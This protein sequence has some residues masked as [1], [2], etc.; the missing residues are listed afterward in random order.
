M[1]DFTKIPLIT[2]KKTPILAK[3]MADVNAVTHANNN[4]NEE[5][6]TIDNRIADKQFMHQFAA[7]SREFSANLNTVTKK[8]TFYIFNPP[9]EYFNSDDREHLSMIVTHIYNEFQKMKTSY[10]GNSSYVR[11]KMSMLDSDF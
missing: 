2:P 5:F 7:R 11:Y 3:I 10:I 8:I 4:L 1:T 6:S 9:D